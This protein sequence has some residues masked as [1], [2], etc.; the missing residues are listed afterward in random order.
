[1]DRLGPAI[2]K[3]RP[4]TPEYKTAKAQL[5]WRIYDLGYSLDRFGSIDRQ[6]ANQRNSRVAGID[7][8]A[9]TGYGRKY[10]W[11]ATCE[12]AGYRDDLGLLRREW[13]SGRENWTH[14][15]LDPSFPE[16]L[17]THQLV[18]GDLLGDRQG[19][20]AEWIACGPDRT[21]EELCE[22]GEIDGER[23]PWVLLNGHIT[24]QDESSGRY[25][26]CFL[27]G[28]LVDDADAA[29][30]E[31]VICSAD[32]I[33]VDLLS[34]PDTHYTYA[35]EIPWCET[36]PA[37]EASPVS[38]VMG[39]VTV[40]ESERQPDDAWSGESLS[41][42][43]VQEA[44]QEY[45]ADATGMVEA[46]HDELT[47]DQRK[48]ADREGHKSGT[49]GRNARQFQVPLGT[50]HDMTIAVT[51]HGW[52]SYH[53]ELNPSTG[54]DVPARQI[55]DLLGLTSRPQ[56]FDLYD[57]EGRRASMSFG[58]GE[59]FSNRQDFTYLR[60]DLLD[61]YLEESGQRLMW[62]ITGERAYH[63]SRSASGQ[64]PHGDQS[65]ARYVKVRL[66]S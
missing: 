66:Y 19:P 7:D 41:A 18:S 15:D 63:P 39:Y 58:H 17:R 5:W 34:V 44:L 8:G 9:I 40:T 55:A 1:M 33:D 22:I 45:L 10:S 27:M 12:L 16:E 57:P 54:A 38:I 60:K 48:G 29:E 6:L 21:F 59:P 65:Y 3:Y 52:E 20:L 24:Q 53:S 62:V 23:G 31:G 4:Q 43:D 36:Y 2:S 28:V 30:I 32:Q 42:E 47:L 46:L 64:A 50:T 11:I 25:M 37:N 51:R 61:R 56:T 49:G 35:G 13:D 26:F 14:V